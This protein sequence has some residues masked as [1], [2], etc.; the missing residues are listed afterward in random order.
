MSSASASWTRLAFLAHGQNRAEADNRATLAGVRAPIG[1]FPQPRADIA[2]ARVLASTVMEG[3][4][5]AMVRPGVALV[6]VDKRGSVA[7]TLTLV[8]KPGSIN[9]GVIGRHGRCDLYLP[10][11][12]SLSLRHAA[13][14][15]DERGG[16]RLIDLRTG[17]GLRDAAGRRHDGVA[18]TDEAVVAIGDHVIIA[19]ARRMED[20]AGPM[21]SPWMPPLALGTNI[22]PD[23]AHPP[24]ASGTNV[25]GVPDPARV[26][27][28]AMTI[29]AGVTRTGGALL[30]GDERREALIELADGGSREM[31]PVGD[32]ALSNGILLGRYERCDGHGSRILARR[33]ISRVHA[34]V[35]A[36]GGA[37]YV[38][39]LGSTNG[40]W[41]DG[42]TE[43]RVA[44]LAPG[45]RFRLGEHG[46]TISWRAA[47]H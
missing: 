33:G 36:V 17:S 27:N 7:G 35:I 24:R 37:P 45:V 6:A 5:G 14:V 18:S 10:G 38:L 29:T 30:G 1:T 9:A 11:D 43:V 31:W 12:E 25:L 23:P 32:R 16:F 40:T 22:A 4:L 15:V 26:P 8:G 42:T 3:L 21:R 19:R 20:P 34:L 39:D 44:R 41:L 13:V 47:G 46:P 2:G 28:L